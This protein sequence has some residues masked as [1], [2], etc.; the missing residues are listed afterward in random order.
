MK[1]NFDDRVKEWWPIK[2]GNLLVKL[3][4]DEGVADEGPAKSIRQMHCHLGP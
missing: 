2:N 4:D 1:K 3:E